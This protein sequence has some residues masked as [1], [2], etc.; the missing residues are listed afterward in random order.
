MEKLYLI[1]VSL[2]LFFIFLLFS[3]KEKQFH[4]KLLLLWFTVVL[5][6]LIG[7]YFEALGDY[8]FLLEISSAVVFLHGPVLWFYSH[9]ILSEKYKLSI[10]DIIHFTPFILN[11]LVVLPWVAR[12]A[13]APF[14]DAV[15][16]I[17]VIFKITSMIAYMLFMYQFISSVTTNLKFQ[18][19]SLKQKNIAWLKLI[20][21][22]YLLIAALGVASQFLKAAELNF[23]AKNEDILINILASLLVIIAGYFGFKQ[24][25]IFLTEVTGSRDGSEGI[26]Y[27]KSGLPTELSNVYW[28]RVNELMKNRKPFLNPDL[29]LDAMAKQVDISPNLLSQVINQNDLTFYDFINEARV[30]NVLDKF[31]KADHLKQTIE[32]IALESGFA[33]KASFNRY[34]KKIT[35]T[36]PSSYLKSNK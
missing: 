31:K 29:S 32:S 22:G 25:I 7:F 17:L 12:G 14:S 1:T 13:F 33:S 10:R 35:G 34:F 28:L 5:F 36:T 16:L 8:L 30:K 2:V 19:S 21:S 18:F 4:D 27:N 24:P 20:A 3:K 9:S 26:K 11:I 15:R 23:F 6:N